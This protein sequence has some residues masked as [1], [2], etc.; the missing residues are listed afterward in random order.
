MVVLWRKG[1]GT[2]EPAATATSL[3]PRIMW[4][5]QVR[6]MSAGMSRDA[7]TSMSMLV[8]GVRGQGEGC[9]RRENKKEMRLWLGKDGRGGEGGTCRNL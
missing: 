2:F 9:G 1:G 5:V 7:A 8:W 3:K 6:R 4:P